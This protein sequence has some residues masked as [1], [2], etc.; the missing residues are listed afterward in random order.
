[1]APNA[2]IVLVEAQTNFNS[3]LFGAVDAA[4]AIVAN[5]GGEVSMSW[6]SGESSGESTYDKHFSGS[7]VVFIASSG[8]VG[9]KTNYP[10]V[11]PYVISAGGTTL[12]LNVNGGL[13]SETG[14]SG[15][16]GGTSPYE[17]QFGGL[18]GMRKVPDLSFDADPATGVS[19]F[20]PTCS[21]SKTGWMIF[22]GT[23]VSAPALAGIINSAA[24]F[25]GN[26]FA[27]N[28]GVE[29]DRIYKLKAGE[30]RDIITGTAGSFSARVGWDFV[31]G[32]GSPIG[33]NGK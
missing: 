17:A 10:G 24:T 33:L 27:G 6:G 28:T 32:V 14:W 25:P 7:N 8:D 5:L 30:Y 29:L 3:D 9:G 26:G 12:K 19:V 22:G 2:S 21:G 23:S 4:A 11:S 16:G 18:G 20:G 15:S 1:M 13:I 31:T